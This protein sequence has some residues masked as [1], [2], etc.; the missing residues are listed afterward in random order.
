VSVD[1]QGL[2]VQSCLSHGRLVVRQGCRSVTFRVGPSDK[3]VRLVRDTHQQDDPYI[4]DV[5]TA[6]RDHILRIGYRIQG[7]VT[8]DGGFELLTGDSR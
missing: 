2:D 3:A 8:D 5:P 4:D 1:T 6:V 7:S